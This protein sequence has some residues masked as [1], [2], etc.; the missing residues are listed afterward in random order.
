VSEQDEE[1]LRVWKAGDQALA[2]LLLLGE[3]ASMRDRLAALEED[4]PAD[5][6]A[7]EQRKYNL[8]RRYGG[9]GAPA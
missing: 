1:I 8:G 2:L 3:V 6:R 4:T 9:E 5:E 7:R